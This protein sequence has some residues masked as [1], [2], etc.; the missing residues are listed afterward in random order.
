MERLYQGIVRFRESDYQSHKDL[1][2]ELG[3]SQSPHTLFIGC[4]DSRVVP[5]LITQTLPGELFVIRNVANI[6]PPYRDT[7]DYVA[8][9][10]AIEY[11]VKALNVENIVVC[12][13]SNCG[14]CNA[15]FAPEETLNAVPHVKK[16]LEISHGVKEKI[17][18]EY[19]DAD[20]QKREWMTEQM[21]V[22]QQMKNLL[23]YPYIK[24]RYQE[25][26][27]SILGWYYIIETGE[28]FSYNK[29]SMEFELVTDTFTP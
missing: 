25:G 28:V 5:N 29:E 7:N 23:S 27:L 21:N 2:K 19:P 4:S 9:L 26:K 8:T 14:G 15:L 24:E 18:R 12:G 11:A 20:A 1:F 16:W 6:V 17:L 22:V 13:H 3:Q 10:S